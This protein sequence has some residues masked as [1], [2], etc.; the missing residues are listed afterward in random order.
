MKINTF[1]VAGL[2]A[3]VGGI[4][5]GF[6]KALAENKSFQLTWA[7]EIDAYACETY[8]HNFKHTLLEGDIRD[9]FNND[10]YSDMLKF[11]LNSKV[12]VLTAGFP[13]QAFSIAGKQNGFKDSRGSLFWYIVETIKLLGKRCGKPRIVFME[14]VKNL[15]SHNGGNTFKVIKSEMEKEGY[16]VKHKVFNTMLYSDLPQNRERV[17]IVC[18]LNR[19]DADKFNFENLEQYKKEKTTN[20]LDTI[21]AIIDFENDFIDTEYIEKYFYTVEKYPKYFNSE[22]KRIGSGLNLEQDIND[23]YK[24]YQ[25]R[26]GLYVRENKNGICPTLTANMGT[27]GHN[28]PLIKTNKGIRKLTSKEVFNLQGFDVPNSFIL[29]VLFNGKKYPESQLYKQ[30]GNSVS[31]PIVTRIAEEILNIL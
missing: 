16:F 9:I 14:N 24:F 30:A 25:I 21:K 6:K 27:G 28:V 18:F 22:L 13:C 19:E 10:S 26:R 23:K 15:V 17:F 20:K 5:L 7:N 8:R 1:N 11:I 12:D 3:G 2:F 31:V 29:P 4:C